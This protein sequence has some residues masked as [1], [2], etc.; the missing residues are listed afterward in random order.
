MKRKKYL[1]I[2]TPDFLQQKYW[3]ESMSTYQISQLI[4]CDPQNVRNYMKFF[5]IPFRQNKK[6]HINRKGKKAPNFK[7]GK[8]FS[9]GYIR[10]YKPT[11]LYCNKKGYVLEHR[12]VMEKYL[13]R[14]LKPEEI[15]HHRNEI[16]EDNRLKNLKLFKNTGQHTS[17]HNKIKPKKQKR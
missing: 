7:T 3:R 2:L 9:E 10:V 5:N 1:H 13:G 14:Y 4:K 6:S 8:L 11:H 16:R 17:F 15:V 12:L